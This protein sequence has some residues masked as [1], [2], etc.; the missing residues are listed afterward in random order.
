M[1]PPINHFTHA[2]LPSSGVAHNG[3]TT[4]AI[5]AI[6]NAAAAQT[7]NTCHREYCGMG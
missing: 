7:A 4:Q 6:G 2:T 3:T 1:S 5:S